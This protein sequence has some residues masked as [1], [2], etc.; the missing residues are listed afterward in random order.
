MICGIHGGFSYVERNGAASPA[1]LIYEIK[2]S[3]EPL[4]VPWI[5][6]TSYTSDS[7]TVDIASVYGV[8]YKLTE[9]GD[10]NEPIVRTEIGYEN[11]PCAIRNRKDIS[12]RI[13]R[14][15]EKELGFIECRE[16]D[17]EDS[18]KRVDN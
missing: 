4:E 16:S 2:L 10:G 6:A 3:T 7:T 11:K 13:Y 18:F 9:E 14:G 1:G 17:I 5:K 12:E 8:Y 15:F